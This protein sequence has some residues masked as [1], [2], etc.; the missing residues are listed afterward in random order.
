MRPFWLLAGESTT[1]L[2][3]SRLL[4]SRYRSS[5]VSRGTLAHRGGEKARRDALA[6]YHKLPEKPTTVAEATEKWQ[7]FHIYFRSIYG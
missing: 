1:L 3:L 5:G 2:Y 6:R 7:T 4:H